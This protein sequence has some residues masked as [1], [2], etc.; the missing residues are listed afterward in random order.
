MA[1]TI[2]GF[3]LGYTAAGA[4]VLWSGIKG[5]SISATFRALLTGTTPTTSTETIPGLGGAEGTVTTSA[6][7][8]VANT[9]SENTAGSG[10]A[11][12]QAI[13]ALLATSYGWGPGTQNWTDLVSLW[14]RESGW[15]NTATNASSGAYG[16]AQALGHGTATTQGT[17]TNEYGGFG[18]SDSVAQDANSGSASA[19]ITWGLAYIRQKWGSPSGAWANEESAGSY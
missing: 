19:Q 4:V 18:V 16:I 11:A 9:A 10:N 12:N 6:A 17:V 8:T 7:G 2:N 3:T 13:G 1:G 15:N 5:W 14:N